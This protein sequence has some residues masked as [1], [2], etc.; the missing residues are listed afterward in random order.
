MKAWSLASD[1]EQNHG[2]GLRRTYWNEIGGGSSHLSIRREERIPVSRGLCGASIGDALRAYY[3]FGTAGR[4][5]SMTG[6]SIPML[7][8]LSYRQRFGRDPRTIDETSAR[9]FNHRDVF[10]M[11]H[12]DRSADYLFVRRSYLR[13]TRYGV[14]RTSSFVLKDGIDFIKLRMQ[15]VCGRGMDGKERPQVCFAQ[16][17]GLKELLETHR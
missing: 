10:A 15:N 14:F 1:I 5:K 13:W 11:H 16:C 8:F 7:M 6:A 4:I 12:P 3:I 2:D 17:R 9:P